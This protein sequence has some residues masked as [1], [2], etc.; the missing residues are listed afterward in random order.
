M[1][2]PPA[3]NLRP[4]ALVLLIALFAASGATSLI[5]QTIWARHLSLVF[6]TSQ[7]A[8]S[9][10]LAAFMGGLALGAFAAA[11][12]SPRARDP[13]LA[14][15]A[16]EALV[17]VY[18]LVFPWIL[19]AAAPV[20]LAFW[21]TFEPGPAVFG[22]FQFALLGL[23]LLPPT[24][25]M[26]ATLPLLAGL[27]TRD[28]D[29]TGT[30]VG[31][32]YGANTLGA[33]A[34]TAAAGFWL[35]PRFGLSTT[36]TLAAA[37]NGVLALT[38]VG[39]WRWGRG[40]RAATAVKPANDGTGDA[41]QT[42]PGPLPA[43]LLVAG[44]CGLAGLVYEIAWFRLMVLVL[45]A[46]AYAF[47]IMLLA[48]LLGIGLGGW[49]GGRVADRVRRRGGTARVLRWLAALQAGVALTAW[50]VMYAYGELP[51]A[52]AWLYEFVEVAPGLIWPVKLSLALAVMVPPALLLGA[53]FP[54][55]VR[56][57]AG[58]AS[59]LPR[60]VG[61]VYGANAIGAVVGAFAGGLFLLP[62]LNVSGTVLAAAS[63]NL[64]AALLALGAA[65][66]AGVPARR[67]RL[68]R[69]SVATAA[70]IAA[71]HAFA[72]PWDAMLMSVGIYK[73]AAKLPDRSRAAVR[74]LA[75]SSDLLFYDE[76]LA[77]VV[78]VGRRKAS[79]DIWLANNGKVDATA[80]G[81][82]DT[83]VLLAQIP[84]A[85]RP[86][87]RNVLVIGLASGIST[88]S[89]TLHAGPERIEV[90]EIEPA[91]LK[92]CRLFDEYNHSPLEDPRVRVVVNDARNHLLRTADGTYDLVTSEPSN[93]W[94]TGVSNLFTREFFELARRKLAPGGVWGQWLHA[95]QMTADDLRSLVGTFAD[96]FPHASLFRIG[97]VDLLLV[98][99][100]APLLLDAAI[101][102]DVFGA[103]PAIGQELA[104][105]GV[106]GPHELLALYCMGRDG[107]LAFAG[108]VGRNTDDNMRI[109]LSAPRSLRLPPEA[110]VENVKLLRANAEV[111]YGALGSIN[112]AVALAFAYA[113]DHDIRRAVTTY[114]SARASAPNHP[115]VL[116]FSERLEAFRTQADQRV[117]LAQ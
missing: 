11:R 100:D 20:Y 49:A 117:G 23:L 48:F 83:Q 115:G 39:V 37:A 60:C 110:T 102:R 45:G 41:A 101:V 32:L 97:G 46:S 92:A 34:G 29:A 42:A 88:G 36:T 54:F 70:A 103:N 73:G 14:Y 98:G 6:G 19:D 91:V 99:S 107:M 10:L 18:A 93:P 8:I 95:Y 12:W 78:T 17:A 3:A 24:F 84:F 5:Y 69:W 75:D 53:S 56:A 80:N 51:Y 89:V 104:E 52:F 16:L 96:V 108:G 58:A 76:G 116:A 68:V 85:Y 65:M 43:L 25:C 47:S 33:V 114:R 38:S 9:T 35:L 55:L 40:A 71:L 62:H 79:G 72:A 61:R 57:A 27:L 74:E 7:L 111:P 59:G 21:R 2:K 90:A 1:H 86:E 44:L 64:V 82:R 66:P 31:R 105:I 94:I 109:E 22:A 4:G 112:D 30:Q 28:A 81:D 106:R 87:A 15:A 113:R 26:G 67:R 50:A 13:L 77:S 63:V